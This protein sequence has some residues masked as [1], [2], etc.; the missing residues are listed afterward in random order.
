MNRRLFMFYENFK[1]ACKENNTS[2]TKVIDEL[3]MSH[4]CLSK[5]S[6]GNLP[7]VKTVVKIA[8]VLEIDPSRLITMR[9]GTSNE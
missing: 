7:T 9:E 8:R 6:K 2:V 1:K 3:G 5:W 4:D